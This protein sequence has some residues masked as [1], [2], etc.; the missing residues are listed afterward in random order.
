[1][2]VFKRNCLRIVLATRRTSRI[3]NSKIHEK[4]DP[5]LLYR[6]IMR[7][8]LRWLRHVLEVKDDRL[9]K[10]VLFGQPSMA[11]RK[12]D[13]PRIGWENVVKNDLREI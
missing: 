7:E 12:V 9:P 10:I 6:A 4:C 11:K 8:R 3:S 1:M 2:D 5:I 13:R